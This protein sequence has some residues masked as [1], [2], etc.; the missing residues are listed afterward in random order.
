MSQNKP[1]ITYAGLDVAKDSLALD[2]AGRAETLPNDAKG[3]ARLLSILAKAQNVHVVLEATGGC[4]QPAV[5]ALHGAG[6]TLRVLEPARVRAFARAKGL[7]AKSDPIDAAVLRAFGEALA[8]QPTLAPSAAQQHLA[9][10]VTRRRQL[11]ETLTA[12]SNRSAHYRELL[13][14]RQAAALWRVLRRQIGQCE[15]AIAAQIAAE[16]E[17]AARAARLQQVPGVGAL[18]AS[19]LLAEMPELG[20]LRDEGAAALAGLAPYHRDRGPFAGTRRIA[21]GRAPVRG[22]LF[23]ASWSSVR[24]DPILKAFYERLLAAGKKKMVALTAVMRKLIVLPQSPAQKPGLQAQ[25]SPL[26]APPRFPPNA[27]VWG[28]RSPSRKTIH[29]L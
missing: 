21:G 20:T 13:A 3:H 8:P 18:T 6:L 17:M 28:W 25:G 12:E 10:L 11:L 14:R 29:T 1:P 19:S 4:E 22:A 9:E 5:R 2:F 26:Q 16:A 15:D 7:R 27:R 23:M 24:H